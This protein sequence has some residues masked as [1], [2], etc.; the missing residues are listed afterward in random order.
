MEKLFGKWMNFSEKNERNPETHKF[1]FKD[2]S[3]PHAIPCIKSSMVA[4]K[5]VIIALAVLLVVGA[6][7]G[8]GVG[9]YVGTKDNGK[10][11]ATTDKENKASQETGLKEPKEKSQKGEVKKESGE[12]N[13]GEA[14]VGSM[15]PVTAEVAPTA[16]PAGTENVDTSAAKAPGAV[17]SDVDEVKRDS[18]VVND[19]NAQPKNNN[20]PQPRVVDK[21]TT[22]TADDASKPIVNP[23]APPA[24]KID[25]PAPRVNAPTPDGAKPQPA[26]LLEQIRSRPKLRHVESNHE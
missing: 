10:A 7:A 6:A 23:D 3:H 9:I 17:V 1:S 5:Q 22:E 2:K 25:P 26:A 11:T 21:N 12:A 8:I 14:K 13:K 15:S 18:A 20:V 4:K 24:P 16:V 19:D